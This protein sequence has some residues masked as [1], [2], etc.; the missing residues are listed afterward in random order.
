MTPND[1]P[2]DPTVQADLD[3]EWENFDL[4]LDSGSD[5]DLP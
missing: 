2:T 3:A 5:Y 1:K 4:G